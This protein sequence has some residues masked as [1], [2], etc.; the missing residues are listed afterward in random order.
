VV[1]GRLV[2]R[3]FFFCKCVIMGASVTLHS[4]RLIRQPHV[5]EV[6]PACSYSW[7][8]FSH[9]RGGVLSRTSTCRN[10]TFVG[11]NTVGYPRGVSAE[12]RDGG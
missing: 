10:C 5:F 12:K 4:A 11:S 3:L 1:A 2:G 6:Q 8:R 9:S 7:I